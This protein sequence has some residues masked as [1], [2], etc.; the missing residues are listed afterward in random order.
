[1]LLVLVGCGNAATKETAPKELPKAQTE[2]KNYATD[3]S[4]VNATNLHEFLGRSDVIYIDLRDYQDYAKKHLKNFEVIPF[5]GSIY[6]EKAHEDATMVQLYGGT[7]E[8]PVAI[9]ESSEALINALFP[10][11][12]TIFLMCQSGGRVV[13]MMKILDKLGYDMTKIYNVGGMGQFTATE[14]EP[15]TTNT[16]EFA[17]EATYGFDGMTR[18]K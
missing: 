1:M 18:K 8:E 13:M 9:Y 17:I 5:F 10:K 16:E 3:K 14:Y 12:K 2:E 11:D 4:G 7:P 15:F 6:N